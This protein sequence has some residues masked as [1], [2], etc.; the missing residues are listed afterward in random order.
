MSKSFGILVFPVLL[1]LGCGAPTRQE[2]ATATAADRSD[3]ADERA[4]H[5]QETESILDDNDPE[6]VQDANQIL[7]ETPEET[8]AE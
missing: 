2:R 3:D 4:D 7:Q 8:P 6:S 1:A 5:A